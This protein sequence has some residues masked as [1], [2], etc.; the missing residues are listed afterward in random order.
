MTLKNRRIPKKLYGKILPAIANT[1]RYIEGECET[2]DDP[3]DQQ[4]D[5]IVRSA[6]QVKQ[7]RADQR[8]MKLKQDAL[9]ESQA[10]LERRLD[11]EVKRL[12]EY[13]GGNIYENCSF[14]VHK[15]RHQSRRKSTVTNQTVAMALGAW[16][17]R[18]AKV[19][20]PQ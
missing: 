1:G 12:D 19:S 11:E 5:L 7:L 18:E 10:H 6:L 2:S 8:A 9:E 20:R 17:T 4:L 14:S 13:T 3:V 16:A 15:A